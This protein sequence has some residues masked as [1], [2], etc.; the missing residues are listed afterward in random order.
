M[1][2]IQKFHRQPKNRPMKPPRQ[3]YQWYAQWKS[4][5]MWAVESITRITYQQLARG[6]DLLWAP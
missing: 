4:T 5:L 2:R 3:S 6:L 1:D